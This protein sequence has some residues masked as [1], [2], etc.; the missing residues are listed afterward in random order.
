M[1][2]VLTHLVVLNVN[3]TEATFTMLKLI[4]VLVGSVIFFDSCLDVYWW[5]WYFFSDDN[6]CTRKPG[7]C[8]GN[9]ECLNTPGS[10]QCTCPEGYKL[11]VS[12]RD[13]VGELI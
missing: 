10:Y 9:A 13:C 1:A 2:G 4:S 6:E 8:R 7:P 11:G 12:E 5:K 3:V